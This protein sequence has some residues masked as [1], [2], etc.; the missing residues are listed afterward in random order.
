MEN[1]GLL[2]A[3]YGLRREWSLLD[4]T[5]TW[6]LRWL[7]RWWVVGHAEKGCHLLE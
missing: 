4:M 1:I 2:V 7:G 6:V 5:A 3:L